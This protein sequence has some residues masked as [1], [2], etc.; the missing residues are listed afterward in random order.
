MTSDWMNIIF[1]WSRV[2]R[3]T[4]SREEDFLRFLVKTRDAARENAARGREV[5]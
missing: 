3:Q 1:P 2:N 4:G 5:V